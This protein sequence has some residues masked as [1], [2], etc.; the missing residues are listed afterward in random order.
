MFESSF[1][2]KNPPDEI[3]VKAK[4]KESKLLIDIRFRIIKINNVKP[5]YNKKILV[6]CFRISEL[7]NESM[8]E[9]SSFAPLSESDQSE[10][11]WQESEYGVFL[12][13]CRPLSGPAS[14]E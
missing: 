11:I 5:E 3:I 8:N 12:I 10:T 2:G 13:C 1:V 4:F 7:L 6:D 14:K 9:S